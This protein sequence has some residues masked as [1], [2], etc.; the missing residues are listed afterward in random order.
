MEKVWDWSRLAEVLESWRIVAA[1]HQIPQGNGYLQ[2]YE[3]DLDVLV[4]TL[5]ESDKN[6]KDRPHLCRA[7]W[8]RNV[9]DA[10]MWTDKRNWNAEEGRA[11]PG[12]PK[13]K[14]INWERVFG[15]DEVPKALS[16]F[17]SAVFELQTLRQ[18]EERKRKWWIDLWRT[19]AANRPVFQC[20]LE[21]LNKCIKKLRKH[22]ELSRWGSR[23]RSSINSAPLSLNSSRR[24][25]VDGGNG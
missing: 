1:E 4:R 23:R 10:D 9:P 13:Y 7:I 15:N 2:G 24:P 16:E 19:R 12:K 3:E 21:L 20:D 18:D 8:R 6:D 14:H 11:P 17:C 25:C 5:K 22:K